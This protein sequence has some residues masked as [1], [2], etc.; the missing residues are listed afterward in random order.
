MITDQLALPKNA[1]APACRRKY[2]DNAISQGRCARNTFE[3][4]LV[5]MFWRKK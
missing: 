2:R 3:A 1:P 5:K 4:L